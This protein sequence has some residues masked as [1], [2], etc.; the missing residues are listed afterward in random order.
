M[1]YVKAHDEAEAQSHP[2]KGP[3][4]TE[5]ARSLTPEQSSVCP[6]KLREAPLCAPT[7]VALPLT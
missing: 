3:K 4:L 7:T 1:R 5:P 2:A 6:F